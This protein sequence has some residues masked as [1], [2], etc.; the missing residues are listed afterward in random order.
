MKRSLSGLSIMLMSAAMVQF[1]S[2]D[3]SKSTSPDGD[4]PPGDTVSQLQVGAVAAPVFSP[5][6]GAYSAAQA[7]TIRTETSGATIYYT[8]DGRIPTETSTRY[9]IPVTVNSTQTL[10]AIAIKSG[11][12]TSSVSLAIYTISSNDSGGI[13]WNPSIR[14]ASLSYGGQT[15]RTVKIGTQTWMAENLNYKVDSSWWHKNNPDSG[16]KYGRFYTWAAAMNLPEYC[17]HVSCASMIT[18]KHQGICPS[19]WHVPSGLDWDTLMTAVGVD[20]SAGTRL[21]SAGGWIDFGNGT[22]TYG[23]RAL[24]GGFVYGDSA[25]NVGQFG[26]W[27]RADE[28]KGTCGTSEINA[29]CACDQYVGTFDSDFS[30]YF[31]YKT[32]RHSVRCLED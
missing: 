2:C 11:Q 4:T 20:D 13:H 5:S 1:S 21:K 24:A 7:V 15:Y 25:S 32:G 29:T 17:N 26:Y 6:G 16:A 12:P 27:W 30:I 28:Q 22:D 23:F 8:T 10:N 3:S 31:G 9:T 19:G 14:Y 18:S